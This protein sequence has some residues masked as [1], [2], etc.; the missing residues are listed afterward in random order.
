MAQQGL[1][2]AEVLGQRAQERDRGELAGLVDADRQVLLLGDVQLDPGATLR[3]DPAAVQVTVARA[4]VDQEIDARRAVQLADDDALGAVDDELTTA[5]HDRDLAEVHLFLDGLRLDQPEAHLEGVPERHPQLAALVDVVAGSSE[6]VA[7][8]LEAHRLVV[9]VDREDLAQES[10][11]ALGEARSR[12]IVGRQEVLVG[13]RLDLDQARE[14]TSGSTIRPV[15]LLVMKRSPPTTNPQ[16]WVPTR[17]CVRSTV[18]P[19]SGPGLRLPP[20]RHAGACTSEG[21]Q[22]RRVADG[23]VGRWRGEER[24]ILH[25]VADGPPSWGDPRK[26]PEA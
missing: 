26:R 10:F 21:I 25:H 4:G 13:F 19:L 16:W 11:E 1:V 24:R 12:G 8:V 3:N 14:G 6:L 2:G 17:G 23:E 5:T 7:D 9:R 18:S 22:D 20:R 15:F